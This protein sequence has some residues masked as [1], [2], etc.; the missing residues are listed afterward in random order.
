MDNQN[1]NSNNKLHYSDRAAY[2]QGCKQLGNIRVHPTHKALLK[3]QAKLTNT[4]VSFLVRYA[5]NHLLTTPDGKLALTAL[6]TNSKQILEQKA[7][8]A[9]LRY[10]L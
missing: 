7:K 1:N 4:N 10:G 9:K 6:R 2:H 3:E 8:L 5:I